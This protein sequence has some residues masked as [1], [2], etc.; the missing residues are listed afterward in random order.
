MQASPRPTRPRRSWRPA[1]ERR[2]IHQA[3]GGAEL[4]SWRKRRSHHRAARERILST[5]A[6]THRTLYPYDQHVP[7]IFYGAGVKKGA[8][9]P[10]T[11]ADIAPARRPRGYPVP[12]FRRPRTHGSVREPQRPHGKMAAATPASIGQPTNFPDLRMHVRLRASRRLH[13]LVCVRI[14]AWSTP[15]F[16]ASSGRGRGRTTITHSQPRSGA[17]GRRGFTACFEVASCESARPA[18]TRWSRAARTNAPISTTAACECSAPTSPVSCAAASTESI[19]GTIYEGIDIY[20]F[21]CSTRIARAHCCGRGSARVDAKRRGGT[22]RAA[23]RRR[24]LRPDVALPDR[25][26]RR[27]PAVFH[28]RTDRRDGARIQRLKDAEPRWAGRPA[29]SATRR[30]SA[31]ARLGTIPIQAKT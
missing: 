16:M 1:H 9:H 29:S 8:Q 11:P 19:F 18:R 7:V 24:W 22:R 23:A 15:P 3:G 20:S 17:P 26:P 13:R 27:H 12:N 4:L 21:P 10:A 28:Q 14:S 6:T 5:S 30:R 25:S 2:P 31:S